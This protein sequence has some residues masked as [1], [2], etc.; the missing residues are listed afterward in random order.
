[1]IP[2]PSLNSI[3]VRFLRFLLVFLGTTALVAGDPPPLSTLRAG[4]PRLLVL[5]SDLPAIRKAIETDPAAGAVY[6]QMLAYAGQ[7]LATPPR[8]YEIGGAEHTLLLTARDMQ[9]RILTLAAMYRLTGDRRFAERARREMIAGAAFPDW[10]PTHFLDTAEMTAALGVGYD[11]LY[12]DLAPGDRDTIRT[13]IWEKGLAPGIPSMANGKISKMHNNWVQVCCGGLTLG[14]LAIAGESKEKSAQALDSSPPLMAKI[15][16]LFAPDGGFEEG[17]VYWNYATIYNVLYLAALDTALGSDFGQSQ[18]KGFAQTGE[19]RMQ[20]IS[21]LGKYANFGDCSEEINNAPQMLWMAKQFHRPDY[22]VDEQEVGA[23]K[24]NDRFSIFELLWFTPGSGSLKDAGVPL[25]AKFDRIN[26]AFMRSA[27]S[28]PDATYIAFKGGDARASHGHL[29]LGSFVMEA[30]GERWAIELGADSYGLPG[31][32][33]KQRWSYYRLGT[34]GQ[35]TLTAD[36]QNEDLDAVAPLTA[37]HAPPGGSFAVVDLKDAYKRTLAGWRRGMALLDANRV[38]LQDEVQ[39][40]A[41]ANVTWNFHT[42]ATVEI[43]ASGSQAVLSQGNAKL[44]VTIL[45]PAGAKF[46]AKGANPPPP[47]MQNPGVTNLTIPLNGLV[48]PETITVLFSSG[49]DHAAPPP[50]MPL[51]TWTGWLAHS[52]QQIGS[53]K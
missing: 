43:A 38:L 1:M 51:A 22:A 25:A 53:V 40:K 23:R 34:E 37:F 15:M 20:A 32:F 39:P 31:Y 33:G 5:D 9:K 30:F 45:S 19:Y 12:S 21:P 41:P 49:D 14:A 16:R 26:L 8:R 29:D 10:N 44:K 52:G 3:P 17:P 6:R 36:D 47:Q 35:N 24:L 50:A 2:S 13:A 48:K 28:D 18:A 4:H 7:M 27:W 42:R 11:W 46:A